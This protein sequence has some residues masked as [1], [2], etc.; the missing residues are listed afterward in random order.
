MGSIYIV[1]NVFMFFIKG[2]FKGSRVGSRYNL[3][4]RY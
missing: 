4:V 1:L 2:S 3:L